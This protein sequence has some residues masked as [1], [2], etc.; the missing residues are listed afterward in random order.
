[1]LS[2]PISFLRGL[3]LS[4]TAL[5]QSLNVLPQFSSDFLGNSPLKYCNESRPSDLFWLDRIDVQPE[6]LYMCLPMSQLFG[7]SH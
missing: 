5:P 6:H 3:L 4:S 7:T 1:M 2:I